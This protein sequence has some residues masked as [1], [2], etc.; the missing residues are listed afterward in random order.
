MIVT[1]EWNGNVF[2]FWCFGPGIILWKIFGLC[3]DWDVSG[4]AGT[5]R[6]PAWTQ[7]LWA[8]GGGGVSTGGT[9]H[10]DKNVR[11]FIQLN[12]F[13]RYICRYLTISFATSNVIVL[14][15]S[16]SNIWHKMT[17]VMGFLMIMKLL[18]KASWILS[19]QVISFFHFLLLLIFPFCVPWCS[20]GQAA[21]VK[22]LRVK[23]PGS[24]EAGGRADWG[25]GEGSTIPRLG[26]S[27][28]V[29]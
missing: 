7:P 28:W 21:I 1:G 10:S 26:H 2:G 24:G 5:G 13:C 19:T 22:L 12:Y 27:L 17:V 14:M 16:R 6:W 8:R 4:R 23:L 9:L 15:Q 25:T 29:Y 18:D 11:V 3:W 20:D